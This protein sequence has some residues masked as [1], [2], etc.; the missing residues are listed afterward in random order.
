MSFWKQDINLY[1]P[2]FSFFT[3]LLSTGVFIL[4]L[5]LYAYL[6]FTNHTLG[7][8]TFNFFGP[9]NLNLILSVMIVYSLLK[10]RFRS[11][12]FT[13]QITDKDIT[14]VR[15]M[16]FFVSCLIILFYL[17]FTFFVEWVPLNEA[18]GFIFIYCAFFVILDRF[19][20][21]FTSRL[22][23][24]RSLILYSIVSVLLFVLSTFT[25][26]D[27]YFWV[28]ILSYMLLIYFYFKDSRK[29]EN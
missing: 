15:G 1:Y 12:I 11:G 4:Y 29:N 14:V 28:E 25:S 24:R 5:L 6:Y 26:E 10:S 17:F 20:S 23:N 16:Y 13:I 8:D 19:M 21:F 2:G 22:D 3:S 7:R 18:S 9:Q 27:N